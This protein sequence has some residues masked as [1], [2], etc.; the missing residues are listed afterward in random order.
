MKVLIG[1]KKDKNI[2][3]IILLNIKNGY[4]VF[5][6]G[7]NYY[8]KVLADESVY[9]SNDIIYSDLKINNKEKE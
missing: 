6:E 7:D 5:S 4:I 3:N 9:I 2:N 8:I 1:N